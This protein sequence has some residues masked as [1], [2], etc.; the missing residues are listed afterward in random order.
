MAATPKLVHLVL[1]TR[2]LA[3]MRAWYCTILGAHIVYENP[4]LSFLTF[5][6]E[7]HRLALVSPPDAPLIERTPLTTGMHH[8]AYSFNALPELMEKYTALK[9]LGI[10][11]TAK[12]QIP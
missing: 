9:A 4:S 7:H 10:E 11:L 8:S 12:S 1:M 5:D 3:E 6:E 2:R